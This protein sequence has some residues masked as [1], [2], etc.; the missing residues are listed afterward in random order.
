MPRV[1]D[2]EDT[3][4]ELRGLTQMQREAFKPQKWN[5]DWDLSSIPATVIERWFSVYNGSKA[6]RPKILRPCPFCGKEMGAKE[7]R[8]HK[9]RC[10]SRPHVHK[11]RE[12]VHRQVIG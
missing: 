11:K 9:P 4:E 6:S 2:T 12:I 5:E 8:E 10:P 1:K 7:L 3:P